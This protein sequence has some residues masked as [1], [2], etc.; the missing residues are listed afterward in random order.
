MSIPIAVIVLVVFLLLAFFRSSVVGWL[1]GAMIFVPLV[2]IQSRIS[3][4]A[5]QVVYVTL[6]II[7]LIRELTGV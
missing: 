1:I 4:T 6:L 2:A 7:I 3:D 5:L